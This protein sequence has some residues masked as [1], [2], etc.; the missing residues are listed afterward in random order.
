MPTAVLQKSSR[1]AEGGNTHANA[2]PTKNN[3]PRLK[4]VIRRLAPGL[5]QSELET[6]L[7]EDWKLG[8]GKVDWLVYKPGKIS[9]DLSKPS[10]PSRA[11]LHLT[12]Q[13]HLQPLSDKVRA[14][15]FQDTKNTFKDACLIGPPSL[16]FAPFPKVP[17]GKKRNDQRQG[18]IDQDTDFQA[19]LQSLTDPITKPA[20]HE[21]ES[22]AL[23]KE[24]T[25]TPLIEA[26]RERKAAKEK[27][28]KEKAAKGKD[29]GKTP[30][31][32]KAAEKGKSEKAGKGAKDPSLEKGKKQSK[33]DKAAKEAVKLLNN[34]AAAVSGK[35]K[36]GDSAAGPVATQPAPE[37]KRE[38]GSAN[39]AKQMLARDLGLAPAGGRRAKKDAAAS[40]EGAA[41]PAEPPTGPKASNAAAAPSPPTGPAASTNSEKPGGRKDNK[42]TRA[43]RRAHKAIQA[44][45]SK[46][47]AANSSPSAAPTILKKD[48]IPTGPAA[49]NAVPAATTAQPAATPPTGPAATRAPPTGPRSPS[50]SA[51]APS[52]SASSTIRHAFLKHANPSQGI[53]EALLLEALSVH[54]AVEAVEI[55][56]R[57]GFAYATFANPEGLRAAIKASPVKVAE[58]AVVVLEKREGG[59]GGRGQQGASAR[60]ASGSTARGGRGGGRGGQ[61]GGRGGG[62]GGNPAQSGAQTGSTATPAP[63][64]IHPG[65]T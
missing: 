32:D 46:A 45:Q 40:A 24:V 8:A 35:A 23:P 16:E 7:G 39:L 49:Q 50:V 61:R 59:T 28:A 57:K 14:T 60:G 12:S 4:L 6:G 42:P 62:G 44:E 1:P 19:F 34:Q 33:A 10:R 63:P 56:K 55:D 58:G 54:G 47:P 43:E 9:K 17:L 15:P 2:P 21:S 51:S 25:T 30:K 22:E 36:D 5:T 13:A 3:A 18:T 26:I 37:R 48:N 65:T 11:Y 27:A 31:E 38:R 41:K 53:T 64:A 52:S 20:P 29:G